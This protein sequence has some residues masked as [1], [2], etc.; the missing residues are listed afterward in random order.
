MIN[1]IG[2]PLATQQSTPLYNHLHHFNPDYL[3]ELS[4]PISSFHNQFLHST[5]DFFNPQMI[6]S[7]HILH[8]VR[9]ATDS[10]HHCHFHHHSY[11]HHHLNRHFNHHHS[12]PLPQLSSSSSLRLPLQPSSPIS[13]TTTV[14]ITSTTSTITITST[15]TT[16]TTANPPPTPIQL[17]T[18][19][20]HATQVTDVALVFTR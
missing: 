7:F 6:S 4:T 17:C 12:S 20:V 16:T 2:F 9:F 13:T 15:I 3:I 10:D 11:H 1:S 14:I 18:R 19:V 5:T 8:Y